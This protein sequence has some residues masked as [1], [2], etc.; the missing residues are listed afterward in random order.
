[1]NT[2]HSSQSE[3]ERFQAKVSS[4]RSNLLLMI[5]FTIVN[6]GLLL[7]NA[8]VFLL[9]SASVPYFAVS[10]GVASESTPV[11]VITIIFAAS[12]LLGYFLCWLGSKKNHGW[13]IAALVLFILDSI[14]MIL[15][16]LLMADISG[17]LDVA[18][19]AYV[20]YY[21]IMGIKYSRRLKTLPPEPIEVVGE[22]VP[23]EDSPAVGNPGFEYSSPL[24][25]AD[26]EVKHRVLLESD[27]LGHHVCY[28]RVKRVNELVI[29]GYVYDE[30]EIL[31]E[32]AH[33][34]NAK[35]EGHTF[36]VGFDGMAH[37]YLRVDGETIAKK[38]R[39]V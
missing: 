35:I 13:M 20:L 12:I 19:H 10:V 27:A 1:M 21:L 9:F 32:T 25:R 4:A 17:I 2:P 29:D 3:R 24:R 22:T 34:L 14:I 11:L 38:L 30:I 28:R 36:Q 8:G 33:A 31:V 18:I 7:G 23:Q 39:L 37:S 15:A 5:V 26:E 16:Y 6:I